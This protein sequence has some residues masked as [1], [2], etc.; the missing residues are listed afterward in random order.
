MIPF[1]L[2]YASLTCINVKKLKC[3]LNGRKVC[4]CRQGRLKKNY[5]FYK[6]YYFK[7]IFKRMKMAFLNKGLIFLNI[8]Y[9]EKFFVAR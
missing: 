2:P 4:Q 6:L 7:I 8:F 9:S 5:L 3:Y 1:I